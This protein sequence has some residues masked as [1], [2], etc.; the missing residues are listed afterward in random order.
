MPEPFRLFKKDRYDGIDCYIH[1]FIHST[2]L[3]VAPRFYVSPSDCTRA[4]SAIVMVVT[5]ESD[6]GV[7]EAIGRGKARD[8]E[9]S[10]DKSL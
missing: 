3:L 10:E 8:A 1:I 4:R 2:S 5:C 7:F 6:N 9:T